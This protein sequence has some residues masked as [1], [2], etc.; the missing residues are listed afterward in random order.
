MVPGRRSAARNQPHRAVREDLA[1]LGSHHDAAELLAIGE[2]LSLAV[3]ERAVGAEPLEALEA[4]GLITV[5]TDAD[6]TWVRFA[7]P[8]AGDVMRDDV[9]TLRRRRRLRRELVAAIGATSSATTSERFRALD[10]RLE[11]GEPIDSDALLRRGHGGAT[12]M[13]SASA[14]RLA[15]CAGRAEPDLP[16]PCRPRRDAHPP[17][18][19]RR[20]IGHPGRDRPTRPRAHRRRGAAPD[21]VVGPPPV[22]RDPRCRDHARHRA[23][24][25]DPVRAAGRACPRPEPGG[26]DRRTHASSRSR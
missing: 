10:W 24:C 15:R 5:D 18:A 6:T 9:A 8:L 13:A 19:G 26:A 2:P 7:H 16:G 1:H 21:P 12:G 22:G 25:G 23:R 14:E 4:R 20:G 17:R 11:L 3:A